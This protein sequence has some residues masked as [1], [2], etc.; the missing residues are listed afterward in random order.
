MK[1]PANK[2]KI[3]NHSKNRNPKKPKEAMAENSNSHRT[4]HT[5]YNKKIRHINNPTLSP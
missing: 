4:A 5:Y 2:Q 3:R 1:Q